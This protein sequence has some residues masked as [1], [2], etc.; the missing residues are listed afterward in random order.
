MLQL[1]HAARLIAPVNACFS[2][3]TITFF[4]HG[5]DIM[6]GEA[7]LDAI[8]LGVR[9]KH[10]R[11]TSFTVRVMLMGLPV[12]VVVI[13]DGGRRFWDSLPSVSLHGSRPHRVRL[14]T[15]TPS[16]R[17]PPRLWGACLSPLASV[18]SI[19][20]ILLTAEAEGLPCPCRSYG[21]W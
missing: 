15:G 17:S 12:L 2:G 5:G 20:W 21:S 11:L 1:Q 7:I 16:P 19:P 13:T 18:M 9:P 10:E 4:R 8:G 14:N 6:P 3:L